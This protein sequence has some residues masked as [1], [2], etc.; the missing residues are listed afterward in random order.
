M[1]WPFT[2]RLTNLSITRDHLEPSIVEIVCR[3]M[4]ETMVTA[5]RANKELWKTVRKCVIGKEMNLT[6]TWMNLH[7]I[8]LRR[9][10]PTYDHP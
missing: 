3:I 1:R 4:Q 10:N 5:L 2:S 7:K 9:N 8:R 6:A